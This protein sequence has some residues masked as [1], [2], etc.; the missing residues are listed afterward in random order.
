M[1]NVH[2][3]ILLVQKK[4]IKQIVIIVFISTFFGLAYPVLDQEF[5]NPW[6]FV[7]GAIIGILGGTAIALHEDYSFYKRLRRAHFLIRLFKNVMLY[8]IYFAVTIGSTVGLINGLVSGSGVIQY[9]TGPVFHD[10]IFHGDYFV[11][12]LYTLFFCGLLSFTLSMSRKIESNV[13]LN[14]ISGK[15]RIPKEEV[16][17]FMSIDLN[18]STE[19]A[20]SLGEEEYFDFLNKFYFD[21]TPAIIA[22]NGQIYRYVGDQVLISWPVGSSAQNSGC[23]STYF[24]AKNEMRKHAEE[25][26]TRWG[27]NPSFKAVV[28]AGT[29]VAGEIGDIKSQFVFHGKAMHIIALIEKQCKSIGAPILLSSDFTKLIDLPKFYRL[30]H[31]SSIRFDEKTDIIDLYTV[32]RHLDFVSSQSSSFKRSHQKYFNTVLSLPGMF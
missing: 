17:V 26:F 32:D 15:Y 12:L 8:T 23:L 22:T 3:H 5:S 2:E 30:K 31:C 16:R 21:L 18:N 6:A 27:I 1:K 9:M 4:R 19:I 10:F 20:E 25:Y 28:H 7:N 13:M 14:M 24:I 11:I 29:I